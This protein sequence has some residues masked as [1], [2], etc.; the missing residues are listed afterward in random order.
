L[1]ERKR[2]ESTSNGRPD[3]PEHGASYSNSGAAVK[4]KIGWGVFPASCFVDTGLFSNMPLAFPMRFMLAAVRQIC[5]D[6]SFF[7]L[8]VFFPDARTKVKRCRG[9]DGAL[10]FSDQHG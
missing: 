2:N 1:N 3:N 9:T 8:P 10:G 4:Q 5:P 7:F 6:H